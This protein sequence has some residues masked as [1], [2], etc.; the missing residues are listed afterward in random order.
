M[1]MMRASWLL[2]LAIYFLSV[3]SEHTTAFVINSRCSNSPQ[4]QPHHRRQQN[5]VRLLE[6]STSSKSS[7][8]VAARGGDNTDDEDYDSDDTTNDCNTTTCNGM[9]DHH[10]HH[11][12]WLSCRIVGFYPFPTPP[13][14]GALI[15]WMFR[16]THQAIMVRS[17]W[18]KGRAGST[19]VLMDFMTKGGERHPVWYNEAVKWNV[20]LGGTIRGEVRVRFLGRNGTQDDSDAAAAEEQTTNDGSRTSMSPQME[21]LLQIARSYNCDMNLYGN[22]CRMFSAR[23]EREV[24]RINHETTNIMAMEDGG[25]TTGDGRVNDATQQQGQAVSSSSS[26]SEIMAADFRCARRVL[27]AGLLPT[28]YPLSALLISYEGLHDLF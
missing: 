14:K 3:I 2:L 26:S 28:L 8:S 17:S 22:N 10:D 23:M 7:L 16:D 4:Q 19:T 6:S 21:R 18:N 11:H 13:P 27:A 5:V 24:E 20:L 12:E 1:M 9:N 15:G 25:P